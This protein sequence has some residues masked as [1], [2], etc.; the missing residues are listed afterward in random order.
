[1]ESAATMGQRV[2]DK[3][4]TDFDARFDRVRPR[5]V[6]VCRAVAGGDDALDLVQDTYLKASARIH[7]LR[8][9]ARF[10]AWIVRIALN[11]AKAVIRSRRREL[12]R[13]NELQAAHSPPS[14]AGLRDLVDQLPMRERMVVVLH[15]GYGY[16]LTEVARLLGL[17]EINVRTLAFRARRRLRRQIE[18]AET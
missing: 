16:R 5:L 13:R 1:V 7:Q 10:D 6:A 15:Y 11:E 17:S 3:R 18:E 14:D 12:Q 4:V 9:P 8:D 2:R